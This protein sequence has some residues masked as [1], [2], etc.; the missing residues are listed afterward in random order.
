MDGRNIPVTPETLELLQEINVPTLSG[1]LTH[2]MGYRNNYMMGVKP[3]A[4]QPS[5]RMVGRA[6]TL[7]FI[8]LRE[9][10]TS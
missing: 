10:E 3:L 5:Q 6:R 8:P 2:G 9:C 7:R 4:I 1:T